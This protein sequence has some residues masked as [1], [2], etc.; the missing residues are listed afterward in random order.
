MNTAEGNGE[1][2]LT[3]FTLSTYSKILF[4]SKCDTCQ[5]LFSVSLC[6]VHDIV[7]LLKK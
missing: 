3:G 1:Q 4:F 6:G 2:Q 5:L 7:G